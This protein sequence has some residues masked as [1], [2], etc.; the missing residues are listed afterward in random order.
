V[1]LTGALHT[2]THTHIDTHIHTPLIP[3]FYN[4][5]LLF[6][7][8]LLDHTHADR[9]TR[10][11]AASRCSALRSR[12][13]RPRGRISPNHGKH[14]QRDSQTR[15]H[16]C[17][18]NNSQMRSNAHER[19]KISKGTRKKPHIFSHFSVDLSISLC[20]YLYLFVD[21]Y[22]HIFMRLPCGSIHMCFSQHGP[23]C[24]QSE[25]TLISKERGLSQN[26]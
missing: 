15:K 21:R 14:T 4:R 24:N 19:K 5:Y 13:T 22:T 17:T 9:R 25:G 10:T 8:P 11:R 7:S 6:L 1:L 16:K 20:I 12:K 23:I 26:L 3:Q 18:Q 2:H